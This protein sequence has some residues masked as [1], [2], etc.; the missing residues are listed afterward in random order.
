[1]VSSAARDKEMAEQTC[2]AFFNLPS[3]R[4]RPERGEFAVAEACPHAHNRV[5]ARDVIATDD[6]DERSG[7]LWPQTAARFTRN[8]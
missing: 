4:I 3:G 2:A 1:L 7:E 5:V 8:E 6:A